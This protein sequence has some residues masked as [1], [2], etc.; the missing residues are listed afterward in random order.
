METTIVEVG[1]RDG[2]QNIKE[3]LT[4]D[5]KKSFI[6]YL[7]DKGFDNIE[8]GAFVR[9]D[10][11]PQMADTPI[12]AGHFKTSHDK[13]W[14]LVPNQKGM[15]SA[16]QVGA[17]RLAFFTSASEV[18][19]RNNIGMSVLEGIQ[20]IK[21]CI[22]YLKDKG[23]HIQD[24]WTKN[25]SSAK[26]LK[27]RLYLST[28]IASPYEGKI[29]PE[30]TIQVMEELVPLGFAQI[31]LGDTLG[32]GVPF[33]WKKLLRAVDLFDSTLIQKNRIAMHCH[34]TYGTALASV[35]FGLEWGVKTFDSSLGGLGGCPYAPGAMG[36]LATEDLLYFL[37]GQG[38]KTRMDVEELLDAFIPERTGALLNISAVVRA[39]RAK[40]SL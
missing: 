26:K 14:Y 29:K 7:L 32:V 24:D 12:I 22:L 35:A 17:T 19:N 37:K 9:P 23:Y 5:Q 40:K 25:D 28:V 3:C 27:L 38:I 31:S 11:M 33:D 13:L 10:K 1:P 4:I 6:Q 18:F 21:S 30:S 8:G 34:N 36:N 39:L 15:E 20:N 16:L 2:L